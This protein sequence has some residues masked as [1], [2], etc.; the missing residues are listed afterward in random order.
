MGYEVLFDWA[1]PG[2][3]PTI[4]GHSSSPTARKQPSGKKPREH[5]ISPGG[6]GE[7]AA[8]ADLTGVGADGESAGGTLAQFSPVRPS[9]LLPRMYALVRH[10]PRRQHRVQDGR[11]RRAG[12]GWILV[13][14]RW[15]TADGSEITGEPTRSDGSLLS[16]HWLLLR[17]PLAVACLAIRFDGAHLARQIVHS[18]F[19]S[20]RRSALYNQ[21][22][23]ESNN[24]PN[25]K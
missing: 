13:R 3:V 8:T 16:C 2:K 20:I 1:G 10:R 9:P 14:I 22:H 6:A 12:G 18:V 21:N 5:A 4:T 25:Q 24:G 11:P 23:K 7:R 17:H 15:S 19:L